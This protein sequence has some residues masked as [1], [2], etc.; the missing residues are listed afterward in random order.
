[1]KINCSEV[2]DW[3]EEEVMVERDKPF[4]IEKLINN[5]EER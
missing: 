2:K 3:C 4:Y 5:N 1:M